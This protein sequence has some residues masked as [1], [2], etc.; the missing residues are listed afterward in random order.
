M[1]NSI[2]V[3]TSPSNESSLTKAQVMELIYPMQAEIK[4][5]KALVTQLQQDI[6]KK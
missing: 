6:V 1:P 2:E 5:L 4:Q 3:P